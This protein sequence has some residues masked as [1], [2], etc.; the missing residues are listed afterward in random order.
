MSR[1]GKRGV[2]RL[3]RNDGRQTWSGQETPHPQG[4]RWGNA[5]KARARTRANRQ[6]DLG[7]PPDPSAEDGF[8][9]VGRYGQKGRTPDPFSAPL[10]VPPTLP[11][12]VIGVGDDEGEENCGGKDVRPLQ[13]RW[14]IGDA[15]RGRRAPRSS[16]ESEKTPARH[17][18]L[19][20]WHCLS[21][22]LPTAIKF[23]PVRGYGRFANRPYILLRHRH[24]ARGC[25][26]SRCETPAVPCQRGC[27]WAVVTQTPLGEAFGL[28]GGAG[29]EG[30]V[31]FNRKS[32]IENRQ[33]LDPSP[34][35]AAPSASPLG[36]A[37]NL[38]LGARG[39]PLTTQS[40]R[41]ARSAGLS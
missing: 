30:A 28:V 31:I 19:F 8:G 25:K 10:A 18:A 11:H 35:G 33:W 34:A 15:H 32:T 29:V 17:L 40:S 6:Q 38:L 27:S 41:R 2:H 39:R 9:V 1:Q 37:G 26:D 14:L 7:T 4:G 23:Q 13:G 24:A 12:I 3:W 22:P 5:T 21:V 16:G 36:E 20:T